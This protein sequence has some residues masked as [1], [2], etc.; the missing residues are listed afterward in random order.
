MSLDEQR[1][2]EAL[3]IYAEGA[4]MTTSDVDR[5]QR[6]LHH[7]IGNRRRAP[8][9]RLIAAVAAVLL[10]IVA[11]AAGTLWLRRPAPPVPADLQGLGP[12]PVVTLDTDVTGSSLTAVR[13]DH[14]LTTYYNAR[15][16][17]HPLPAGWTVRWR[18]EGPTLV[19]DGVSP[20]GLAC[21]GSGPWRAQSDGVL[22]FDA[23]VLEGPGCTATTAPPGTSTRLSPASEPG[24]KV[25][26]NGSDLA[27]AVIDPAQLNGV[28]LL[29]GT[30]LLLAADTMSGHADYVLDDDGDIDQETDAKGS[31]NV[32]SD[33]TVTLT[34]PSCPDTT[35]SHGVLHG[36]SVRSL[37]Q[38]TLVAD[39][40]HRF[41]GTTVLTWVRV[42]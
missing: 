26:D 13:P 17:V 39:P 38:L 25:K 28:W 42:L 34:S 8:R 6:E 4:V 23:A 18:V 35:L 2:A 22:V 32:G 14:T 9:R 37:L 41:G 12:L 5:M 19:T 7:R 10:L 1:L 20:Q 24:R 30:G 36:T 40:C 11:A 3:T 33:G 29:Q 31:L 15:D 16:I 21:R 27:L